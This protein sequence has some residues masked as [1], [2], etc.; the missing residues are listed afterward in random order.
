MYPQAPG[1]FELFIINLENRKDLAAF[2]VT[3]RFFQNY[4]VTKYRFSVVQKFNKSM[5][6][7]HPDNFS[8]STMPIKYIFLLHFLYF[9]GKRSNCSGF[10]RLSCPFTCNSNYFLHELRYIVPSLKWSLLFQDQ[11]S[12]KRGLWYHALRPNGPLQNHPWY[13]FFEQLNQQISQ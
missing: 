1:R 3:D 11:E 6:L 12:Q 2:E 5:Q 4:S 8:L 7:Q 9:V 10:S 13:Q